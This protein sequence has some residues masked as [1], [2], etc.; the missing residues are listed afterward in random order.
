MLTRGGEGGQKSENLADIICER[1]QTELRKNTDN[2]HRKLDTS[3][4]ADLEVPGNIQQESK[5]NS[6]KMTNFEHVMVD[7][8]QIMSELLTKSVQKEIQEHNKHIESKINLIM[9][10]TQFGKD[11]QQNIAAHAIPNTVEDDQNREIC[12]STIGGKSMKSIMRD[13]R[14][15]AKLEESEK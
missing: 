15:D 9:E 13:A 14:N 3:S 11:R 12:W 10:T 4:E 7:K 2:Q 8:I 6:N 5:P 1:S